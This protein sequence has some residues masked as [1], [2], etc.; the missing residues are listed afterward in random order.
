MYLR[1]PKTES[2]MNI[3]CSRFEAKYGMPEAFGC[4]DGTHIPIKRP[5]ENSQDF[6]CY[7]MFY[8][9]NVQCIC[10]F[11]GM[12]MDI[13]CRWPGSVHD[14]KVFANSVVNQKLRDRLLPL[15]YQELIPGR[16]KI[17]NYLIGDPAYP[18][19]PYSMKE[20]E[21]CTTNSHVVFNS[22]LRSAR[23]PVECAFGRLKARWSI[24]TRPIDLKLELVPYVVYSCFVLHNFC[25]QSRNLIDP[26]VVENQ[27]KVK[28]KQVDEAK[29]V[30]DPVFSGNLDEGAAIRD[31]ITTYI[32]DNLPDYL[33]A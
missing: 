13:D 29:N 31:I 4:I 21:S 6:F 22:M 9:L 33:V 18:L 20:Y 26:E 19:T 7:K 2:E 1:L 16:T 8:S 17:G 12:F 5:T 11:S 28:T 3:K 14:A 10:D 23:N 25:E 30:P 32:Q 27:Y 24:L 15:T